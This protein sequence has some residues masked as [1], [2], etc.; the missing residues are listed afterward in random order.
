MQSAGGFN[1]E[2]SALPGRRNST[3]RPVTFGLNLQTFPGSAAPLAH[4]QTLDLHLKFLQINL[5]LS[6]YRH[7]CVYVSPEKK[8]PTLLVLFLWRTLT[9]ASGAWDLWS[10]MF[11]NLIRVEISIPLVLQLFCSQ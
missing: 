6:V 8:N 7:T 2:N 11:L 9:N 10:R 1:R 5:S 3:R 4:L